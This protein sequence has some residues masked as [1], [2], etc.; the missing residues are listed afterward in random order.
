[1]TDISTVEGGGETQMDILKGIGRVV[2][3][4]VTAFCIS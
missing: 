4:V 1:M 3:E 2:P